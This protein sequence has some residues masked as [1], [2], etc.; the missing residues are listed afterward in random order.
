MRTTTIFAILSSTFANLSAAAFLPSL[1]AVNGRHHQRTM[2]ALQY[3]DLPRDLPSVE[4]LMTDDFT[5]QVQYASVF[6]RELSESTQEVVNTFTKDDDTTSSHIADETLLELLKAQ[7]SH[8][9]GMRGFFAV[10]LT[11]EGD[12]AADKE[13]MPALLLE[14]IKQ[15]DWEKLAPLLCKWIDSRIFSFVLEVFTTQIQSCHAYMK[16][17]R[18][19]NFP[20]LF[21]DLSIQA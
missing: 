11:A 12:T 15:S 17:F 1:A 14:V 10:Y 16:M 7:F 3:R 5:E 9:D 21:P 19:N 18:L 20:P 2:T 4:E 8:Q 6:V 13:K